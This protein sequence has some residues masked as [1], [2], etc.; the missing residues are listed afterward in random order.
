MVFCDYTPYDCEEHFDKLVKS[1]RTYRILSEII[2]DVEVQLVKMPF[3]KPPTSYHLY[4]KDMIRK[5]ETVMKYTHFYELSNRPQ[6]F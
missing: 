5:S 6:F 4:I 2:A 1:V 3:K